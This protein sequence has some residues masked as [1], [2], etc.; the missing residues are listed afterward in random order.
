VSNQILKGIK[1][2]APIFK[3][4]KEKDLKEADVVTRIQKFLEEALGYNLIDN[5]TKEFQIKERFVD[6]AIKIDNKVKFYIEAKAANASLK[7]SQIFQAES[8]ASQSGV[9]WVVLTNGAEWHLYRLTFDKTG[10]EHSLVFNI[11]LVNGDMAKNAEEMYY[12]SYEAV[13]TNDIADFWKKC[14]SLHASSLV[15]ALFHEDTLAAI[16]KTIRRKSD[17]IV[18]ED[19]IVDSIKKLLSADV[20]SQYSDIIKIGRRRRTASRDK[21]SDSSDI[22]QEIPPQ[23][24]EASK[25]IVSQVID[26]VNDIK[27]KIPGM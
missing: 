25:S 8:Y 13:K 23:T 1:K 18:D 20:L 7:E 24:L 3:D 10:I 2:Y 22:K 26:T 5:I 19:D 15:K 17:I 12:L 4:A 14:M 16:R 21:I 11:D 6:M 27:N 9:E